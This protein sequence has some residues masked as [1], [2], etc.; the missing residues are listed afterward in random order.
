MVQN[1]AHST[2]GPQFVAVTIEKIPVEKIKRAGAI[3]RALFWI[4]ATSFAVVA[5]PIDVVS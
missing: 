5:H 3:A 2:L 4:V 1:E